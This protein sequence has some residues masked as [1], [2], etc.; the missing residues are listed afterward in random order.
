[1]INTT[2]SKRSRSWLKGLFFYGLV[3]VTGTHGP[4]TS[5]A[6]EVVMSSPSHNIQEGFYERIGFGM[7]YSKI[8]PRGGWFFDFNSIHGA[9]P[10]FGG[11]AGGGARFG[12]GSRN[13]KSR[14]NFNMVM[15]QGNTRSMTMVA[16]SITVPNGYGG[17]IFS[18]SVRPFVTGWV[19]VVGQGWS[20]Q[21]VIPYRH[22]TAH[23]REKLRRVDDSREKSA[24]PRA[25]EPD[26]VLGKQV[27]PPVVPRFS[28]SADRGDDSLQSIR[29]QLAEQDRLRLV[30]AYDLI[31]EGQQAE[32]AG[33]KGVARIYY[34]QAANRCQ[35]T[36][37]EELLRHC[38]HLKQQD[39]KQ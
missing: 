20:V 18:G 39:N 22:G 32:I 10:P 36:L 2:R 9:V 12:F 26:L 7:G 14:F 21:P 3:L 4:A 33:K 29:K 11:W 5:H 30:E 28:S 24:T 37:R 16:P 25:T 27:T 1:M 34:R 35:G 15:A 23:L 19:P 8:G 6:Q 17:S 31:I 38:E 13:G